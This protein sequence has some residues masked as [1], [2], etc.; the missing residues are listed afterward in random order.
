MSQQIFTCGFGFDAASLQIGG[1]PGGKN[2]GGD[3]GGGVNPG[4][5]GGGPSWPETKLAN[6]SPPKQSR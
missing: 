6:A 4:G 1:G 3:P 2:G 5:G